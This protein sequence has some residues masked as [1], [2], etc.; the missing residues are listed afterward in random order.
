M[1][2]RVDIIIFKNLKPSGCR[3]RY[4]RAKADTAG[5][6]N[7]KFEIGEKKSEDFLTSTRSSIHKIHNFSFTA[8]TWWWI[9]SERLW[10]T[11]ATAF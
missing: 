5:S 4:P 3:T 8:S 10:K 9:S 1:A 6:L 2:L 7:L 11:T